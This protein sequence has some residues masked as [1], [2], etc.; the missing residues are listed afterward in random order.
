[1]CT[2]NVEAIIQKY[3]ATAST[4][5]APPR[6]PTTLVGVPTFRRGP[7]TPTVQSPIFD[8]GSFGPRKI[9]DGASEGAIGP[10]FLSGGQR[11]SGPPLLSPQASMR[12]GE[13]SA[14]RIPANGSNDGIS[15]PS[16]GAGPSMVLDPLI[17]DCRSDHGQNLRCSVMVSTRFPTLFLSL[18]AETLSESS[19]SQGGPPFYE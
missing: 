4:K 16:S 17:R 5:G 14:Q 3:L 1:M 11:A 2:G 13:A 19:S 15:L 8:R 7:P 9:D 12:G 18:C 6:S 10:S